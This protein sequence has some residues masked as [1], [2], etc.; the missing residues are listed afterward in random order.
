M[1]DDRLYLIHIA[2]CIDRILLYTADG[3]DAFFGDT[4]TQDAVLRNPHV[5]TES[6]QRISEELRQQHPEV[7]WRETARFRNVVVHQYL[8]IDLLRVWDIIERDLPILRRQ[9]R[10]MLQEMDKS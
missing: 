4:R 2:E 6:T 8:G 3:R 9:V 7:A 5:L 1:R 10:A